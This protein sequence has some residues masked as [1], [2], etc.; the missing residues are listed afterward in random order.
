MELCCQQDSR[1]DQV[2]GKI[3]WNGL[4]YLEVVLDELPSKEAT[5]WVYFLGKLPPEFSD[6]NL[7]QYLKLEG[8]RRITD[9]RILDVEA[10]TY[11]CDPE[12]DDFL[13]VRLD[14]SGDFS[15][16]TLSLVGVAH[17]DKHY[18]HLDFSFKI[19]CP[20]DLDCA[21]PCVCEPIDLIEPEINYLAKDYGSFRQ[22][23]LDRLAVLIPDWAE[24]HVPDLGIA[25]VELQ[26]YVGDYLSY[27]Q[28]AVATEAYLETARQRISVRRH[29]RLVD[30]V[31]HEGCNSRAWISVEVQSNMPALDSTDIAFITGLNNA[32]PSGQAVLN[33]NDLRQVPG[34][35]YEVFEPL[36]SHPSR[37]LSFCSSRSEIL[38]YTWGEQECCLAK[39]STSATLLDRWASGKGSARALDS[40]A[41][42]D[43]L[44]FEEVIGSKTG[45]PEDAD[46]LRRH[47]VRVAAITRGCDPV[48][49]AEGQPTP[50]VEIQWNQEDALPFTFCVSVLGPSPDCRYIQNIS[51]ARG[52]VLLVDLGK[53]VNLEC[54]GEVQELDSQAVCQCEGHPGEIQR[55]P[56]PFRPSLSKTPLTFSVPLPS[57]SNPVGSCRHASKGCQSQQKASPPV[58]TSHG[59]IVAAAE[60]AG[61]HPANSVINGLPPNIAASR[62]LHQDERTALPNLW[63]YSLA[64]KWRRYFNQPNFC[65]L[66]SVIS[67]IDDESGTWLQF[68][69][70][71]L[72]GPLAKLFSD[73]R[74][75][76]TRWE[77]QYDLLESEPDDTHFVVEIDN[78]GIAQLR[79]GDGVLGAQPEVGTVFFASYRYGNGAVGNVGAESISRL[80]LNK[81]KLSGVAITVRNPLP[82]MGGID[83]EPIAEA[84]LYA[85]HTF[86]KKIER[87]ITADDY[88]EIAERNA[89]LQRASAKL[90]WTGSWYEADVAVDPLGTESASQALLNELEGNLYR[91]RRM[92]HDLRVQPACYVPIDLKL[93]ICVLPHYQQAHVKAALLDVFSNRK[94]AGGKRGFFHPDNLTF[95]S[96]L[97]ISAI[98]AT[99][100]KVAG[101]EC[102][103]VTRLK[104]QFEDE[105]AELENGLL[106]LRKNEIAQLD[107]DPV[108]PERGKLELTMSGG[109]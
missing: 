93:E 21:T 11:P 73:N 94:L 81:T 10:V 103:R 108:Y 88:R 46:P 67:L 36:P 109:R 52:N 2:R 86:R 83:P 100:M 35:S 23:I 75:P 89:K 62:W 26:A 97:Y 105:N 12:K 71:Q 37:Q 47:A 24:R 9:I 6:D 42:G 70:D 1:R 72:P 58:D 29:V 22:L 39:G 31:L 34:Q 20:Q 82:A 98:V 33:W 74:L 104:R 41:V 102:A 65:S 78:D 66:A 49:L 57:D 14:K 106:P 45:L 3:G 69:K 44:I 85:P 59:T 28:D 19:D 25:L 63:L 101:V 32:L 8:G 43:V 18:D 48:V 77:V 80:V 16:Y 61:E 50:Y 84:K 107:N 96:D 90:A 92:G 99:A 15:T 87:A 64:A 68:P 54:L 91:Y 38:F 56:R 7:S 4:D 27:Y 17:V 51:I 55:T 53:T 79:F 5:L 95:G 60:A 13:R 76:A 40:L 30:Y